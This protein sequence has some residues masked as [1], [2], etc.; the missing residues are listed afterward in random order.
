LPRRTR[1]DAELVSTTQLEELLAH[2]PDE[3]VRISTDAGDGALWA[4]MLMPVL[5]R[6]LGFANSFR[7]M[8]RPDFARSEAAGGVL[9]G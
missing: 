3:V 6:P 5:A 7:M 2:Q 4:A 9:G 1:T 8:L